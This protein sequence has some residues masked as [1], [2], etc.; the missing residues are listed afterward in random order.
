[1]SGDG[2][3]KKLTHCPCTAGLS[4]ASEYPVHALVSSSGKKGASTPWLLWSDWLLLSSRF[5]TKSYVEEWLCLCPLLPVTS[6][7]VS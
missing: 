2:E 4:V 5:A 1:M 6:Q 3:E 7:L